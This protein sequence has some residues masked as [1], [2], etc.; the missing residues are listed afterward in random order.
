MLTAGAVKYSFFEITTDCNPKLA[1]K[2]PKRVQPDQFLQH[3]RIAVNKDRV[4]M[5]FSQ[6]RYLVLGLAFY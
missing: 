6:I 2:A 4:E 3:F 1:E 5:T